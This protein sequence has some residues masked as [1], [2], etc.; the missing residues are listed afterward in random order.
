ML[1]KAIEMY[2]KSLDIKLKIF[3]ENNEAIATVILIIIF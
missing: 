2:K 1:P 3:G